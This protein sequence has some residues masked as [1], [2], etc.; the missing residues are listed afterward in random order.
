M[1][2]WYTVPF[3]LYTEH[4]MKRVIYLLLGLAMLAACT[5]GTPEKPTITVTI[6]PLR[7][8]AEQIGGDRFDVVTMV[9]NGASPETYEPTAQQMA[10][11][12][13]SELYIKAGNLG[14]ERTWMKR[15][16][17]NAQHLIVV[18]SSEG[19]EPLQVSKGSAADPHTWTSPANALRIAHN[20]CKAMSRI[21]SKDSAYFRANL[22]SLTWKIIDLDAKIS[23]KTD[24]CT[25]RS[26]IIY[27]PALTYFARDYR[28]EQMAIE[29]NGHEPS[30]ASLAKLID[31]ARQ[32]GTRIMF[33]QKE[34]ANRNTGVVAKE[35]NVKTIEI[36][37]LSYDWEAELLKI[38]DA[39]CTK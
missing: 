36:N 17:A 3:S 18:D 1:W 39:L 2:H 30:A 29:A 37:P 8:F 20:I 15:L 4:K 25:N 38:A 24:E 28:L 27:H 10:A 9:P 6:E 23:A 31:S 16:G 33:V 21:D 12:A 11:L 26:F 35:T 5:D 22:D 34:F 32:K 13:K 19:I 7:Y 14:F